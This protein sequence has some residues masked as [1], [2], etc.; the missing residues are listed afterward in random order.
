MAPKPRS[1]FP[2]LDSLERQVVARNEKQPDT[3]SRNF[4]HPTAKYIF[5][6]M[7]VMTVIGH[8]V[9]GIALMVME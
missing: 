8:I 9:G 7:L 6:V 5:V 1:L 3:G 2:S 4:D